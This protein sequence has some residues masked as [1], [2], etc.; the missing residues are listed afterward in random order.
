MT[1]LYASFLLLNK[2]F[3]RREDL[4]DDSS[5]KTSE[6]TNAKENKSDKKSAVKKKYHFGGLKTYN[7]E[8]IETEV[9]NDS[10]YLDVF[11][12]SD[13]RWKKDIRPL[14]NSLLKTLQLKPVSYHFKHEDF[15]Q[16]KFP[17]GEEIGLIAQDVE[18]V[19]PSL[20]Q[21]D[22]EGF[23][24]LN[25]AKLTPLL[26]DSIKELTHELNKATN[27]INDLEKKLESSELFMVTPTEKSL[28]G[29]AQSS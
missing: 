22:K 15:P 2:R 11:A 6:N 13:E 25:Y 5:K 17:Q 12:G 4:M 16:K 29:H 3:V 9:L 10:V 19:I 20:I 21:K 18:K 7:L 8:A 1:Y 28:S 24:H 23:C 14:K 26:V 27:R